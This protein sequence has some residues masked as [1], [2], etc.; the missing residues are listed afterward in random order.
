MEATGVLNQ[1]STEVRYERGLAYF[2]RCGSLNQSLLDEL[3]PAFR[4]AVPTTQSELTNAV[5]R[6]QIRFSPTSLVV[7]QNGPTT[8]AR[9]EKVA[10]VA[11]DVLQKALPIE[12]CVKRFGVR[13]RCF[14]PVS[15]TQE[16]QRMLNATGLASPPPGW[17][18]A[19]E[20]PTWSA[21]RAVT[22]DPRGG[23]IRRELDIIEHV[24]EGEV[25][26]ETR[27][28]F[29][30]V[31]VVLDVDYVFPPSTSLAAQRLRQFV[32]DAWKN[33]QVDAQT[34]NDKLT[35]STPTEERR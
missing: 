16:A 13:L 31:A 7:V 30:A 32:Q 10:G 28:L 34:L 15:S 29:P 23:Q 35:A 3:G 27:R 6:I 17:T 2:D 8:S 24:L 33:F 14:W 5:E 25:N 12:K 19:F 21:I 9:V 4:A 20:Q 18:D 26:A 11:W 1:L 22:V